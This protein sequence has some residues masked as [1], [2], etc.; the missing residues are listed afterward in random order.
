MNI[1]HRP[2]DVYYN[3]NTI[4]TIA[5]TQDPSTVICGT[6]EG[7]LLCTNTI[8][9]KSHEAKL[10]AFHIIN[11]QILGSEGSSNSSH[12][13]FVQ[14]KDGLLFTVRISSSAHSLLSSFSSQII[15]MFACPALA[16]PSHWMV[17]S[18]ETSDSTIRLLSISKQDYSIREEGGHRYTEREEMKEIVHMHVFRDESRDTYSVVCVDEC[19]SVGS[20]SVDPQNNRIQNDLFVYYAGAPGGESTDEY[21]LD[22]VVYKGRI[23]TV[24]LAGVSKYRLCEATGRV[25]KDGSLNNK[26]K[27]TRYVALCRVDDEVLMFAASGGAFGCIAIR[28]LSVLFNV[29]ITDCDPCV[30]HRSVW[31][32]D[33]FFIA[34]KNKQM[35]VVDLRRFKKSKSS[36]KLHSVRVAGDSDD[37]PQ[38]NNNGDKVIREKGEE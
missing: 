10:H 17:L 16:G 12:T 35:H 27:L 2:S 3:H 8:S 34:Y 15:G 18:N 11:T 1:G 29:Y 4:S 9:G 13:V 37:S 26:N 24:C 36:G 5:S 38:E 14:F 28:D 6:F 22:V 33:I 31:S 23:V 20:V 32:A 19:L 7:S 21:P 25:V 30:I